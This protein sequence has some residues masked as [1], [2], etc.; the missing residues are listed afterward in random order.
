M[1]WI[2]FWVELAIAL[3]GSYALLYH[4]GLLRGQFRRH[5]FHYYTNLSNLLVVVFLLLRCISFLSTGKREGLLGDTALF[6]VAMSILVTFLI[7]H[8]VLR[9]SILKGGAMGATP[10]FLRGVGNLLVHYVV[11]L[12]TFSDWLFLADKQ[13]L[14]YRHALLWTLI[15]LTYMV[16]AFLR[17]AFG[18]N[19]Q[20]TQSKY[21]YPFMDPSLSGWK[22]VMI[23]VVIL[24]CIF[25][26]LGL[27][28]I[29]LIRL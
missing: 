17:A 22:R 13:G 6:A 7:F 20:G 23:N 12:A 24:W 5:V 2:V 15:P 26:L 9:P 8:L 19:L 25:V 3:T 21:P 10:E 29:G 14:T 4:S 18:K 11:P 27:L 1:Q 28:L 16:Y